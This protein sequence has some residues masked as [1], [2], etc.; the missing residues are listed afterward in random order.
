M[1]KRKDLGVEEKVKVLGE[2]EN[3]KRKEL[4]CAGNLL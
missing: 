3:A 4:P 1:N 2:P